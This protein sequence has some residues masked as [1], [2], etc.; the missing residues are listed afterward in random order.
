MTGR[1]EEIVKR[2]TEGMKGFAQ[3]MREANI[4]VGLGNPPKCVICGVWPCKGGKDVH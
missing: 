4:H 2:I 3:D 1:Q